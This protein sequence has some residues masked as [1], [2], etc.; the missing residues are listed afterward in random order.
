[1]AA[2]LAASDRPRDSAQ[3]SAAGQALAPADS[4]A[5]VAASVQEARA[6]ARLGD[7]QAAERALS[8]GQQTID[9]LPPV[10]DPQHH[11]VFD[12]AKFA[13]YASITYLWLRLPRQAE[14]Y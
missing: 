12:P 10:V 8:R 7:R 1:T 9:R 5:S 4:F 3:F 2:Y 11:F 6:W 13:H 14:G